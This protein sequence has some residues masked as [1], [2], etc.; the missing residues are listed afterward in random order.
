MFLRFFRKNKLTLGAR[1]S[2]LNRDF[3]HLIDDFT[4]KKI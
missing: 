2:T 1:K 3:M 4:K